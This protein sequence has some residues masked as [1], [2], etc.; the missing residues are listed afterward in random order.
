MARD[1]AKLFRFDA[2][3]FAAGTGELHRKGHRVRLSEQQSR[4]LLVLLESSGEVVSREQLR[5][6]LWPQGEHLDHDHAIRNAINQL[7]AVFRDKPGQP[8]FIETL[9][10]RGYR[11]VATVQTVLNPASLGE[12]ADPAEIMQVP[13]ATP[14]IDARNNDSLL[15]PSVASRGYGEIAPVPPQQLQMGLPER[16]VGKAP[17]GIFGWRGKLAVALVFILVTVIGYVAYRRFHSSGPSPDAAKTTITL[18][19]APIDASGPAAQQLAGSFRLELMDAASQL[20]GVEVRAAHSFPDITA[21]ENVRELAQK[22][23]LDA[24]LL[25]KIA[26]S[27]PN[28][29]SFD[30]EL[31]RGRDAVHLASFHYSGT[32]SQLEATRDQIQR[33]LFVRLKTVAGQQLKPMHSTDNPKAYGDYLAGRAEMIRHDDAALREAVSDFNRAVSED[34][35]FAQAYAGLGSA[36]LLE[37]EHA[38]TGRE[39]AYDASR[40]AAVKAISIDPDLG[41]A[42]ATLGFLDFRHD[43]NPN[44]SEVE[45]KRAI[46]LDPNQAMHRILYALLLCNTGRNAE[47]LKQIAAARAADPLWPSVYITEIFVDSAARKND[48]AIETARRLIA[49]M[50]NWSLAYDQ[51]AW[52][53]WYAGRH[54]EAVRQWIHMAELDQDQARL[55]L[56]EQGLKTLRSEGVVAY[57]RMKLHAIEQGGKWNHPNDFQLAEWQ[58]NAGKDAEALVSLRQM[59]RDHDPEALQFAASPA[60][61]RLHSDPGFQALLKQ[62]GLPQP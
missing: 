58:I 37:G 30:F 54:E 42:H 9:P 60:Y 43:W 4:L 16:R 57:S 26:G 44:A 55:A 28:R 38:T 47:A 36:Y 40:A 35:S 51:G 45:F 61:L 33:D 27:D 7:R 48:Q 23:Q 12:S 25:G 8:R 59:V 11:F 17:L 56:E 3:E 29:F 2:Y 41:E 46:E 19:I 24:M 20:P 18:G 52:A 13:G 6:L 15:L 32:A 50:P 22:L 10:K 53:L 62:V 1:R 14:G 34:S 49:M 5:S 39:A 31:V 21:S